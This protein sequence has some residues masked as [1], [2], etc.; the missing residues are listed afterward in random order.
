MAD[1]KPAKHTFERSDVDG[2]VDEFKS[3]LLENF[4]DQGDDEISVVEIE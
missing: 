2:I 3:F 4:K 1:F